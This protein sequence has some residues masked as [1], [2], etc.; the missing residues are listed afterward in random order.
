MRAT[1]RSTAH[2]T[3]VV[4]ALAVTPVYTR[5]ACKETGI[6]IYCLERNPTLSRKHYDYMPPVKGPCERTD[7]RSTLILWRRRR[8]HCDC[9]RARE[10]ICF[11]RILLERRPEERNPRIDPRLECVERCTGTGCSGLV[12]RQFSYENEARALNRLI[13]SRVTLEKSSAG[14]RGSTLEYIPFERP[15]GSVVCV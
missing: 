1:F 11:H 12:S 5:T 6:V 2:L 9:T 7:A 10:R 3:H 15:S 14:R 4:P 13:W 8:Y